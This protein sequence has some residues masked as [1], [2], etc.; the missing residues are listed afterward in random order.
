[1][2]KNDTIDL[3]GINIYD[4]YGNGAAVTSQVAWYFKSASP[5]SDPIA[6]CP[7][8][9][10]LVRNKA[11]MDAMACRKKSKHNID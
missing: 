11:E 2:L 1:M 3:D 4:K 10:G 9:R 7:K 6:C 5:F 8:I